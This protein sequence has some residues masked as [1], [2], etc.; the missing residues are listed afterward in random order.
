[1]VFTFHLDVYDCVIYMFQDQEPA[2]KNGKKGNG[3]S[4]KQGKR[5][6]SKDTKEVCMHHKINI[7][8][9]DCYLM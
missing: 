5:K 3:N 6:K 1:M 8:Q 7:Q 2:R 9:S 4:K